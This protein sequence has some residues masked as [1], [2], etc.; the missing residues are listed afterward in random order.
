MSQRDQQLS[1][2]GKSIRETPRSQRQQTTLMKFRTPSRLSSMLPPKNKTPSY[3]PPPSSSTRHN[4]SSTTT[5]MGNT[6]IRTVGAISGTLASL[7]YTPSRAFRSMTNLAV[8]TTRSLAGLTPFK[9]RK[10]RS[11]LLASSSAAASNATIGS[12]LAASTLQTT[13]TTPERRP[14][15]ATE[16]TMECLTTLNVTD[17]QTGEQV[18]GDVRSMV[19]PQQVD[20]TTTLQD[21]MPD[22]E[23][24]Y[25]APNDGEKTTMEGGHGHNGSIGGARKML[26][27]K[28]CKSKS[29]VA[30]DADRSHSNPPSS[31]SMVAE[32]MPVEDEGSASGKNVRSDPRD[33]DVVMELSKLQGSNGEGEAGTT[34]SNSFGQEAREDD[35]SSTNKSNDKGSLSKDIQADYFAEATMPK[36]NH[37][38]GNNLNGRKHYQD[39]EDDDAESNT[40]ASTLDIQGKA[41]EIVLAAS[42]R[43]RDNLKEQQE[44]LNKSRREFQEMNDRAKRDW[45][46][47]YA[48]LEAMQR[49]T[50]AEFSTLRES[51]DTFSKKIASSSH[52]QEL[53]MRTLVS[54]STNEMREESGRAV[55]LISSQAKETK[56]QL[57]S[58]I[59]ALVETEARKYVAEMMEG[60][61]ADA[62][63][64][65]QDWMGVVLNSNKKK[66]VVNA[67]GETVASK[68]TSTGEAASNRIRSHVGDGAI[69]LENESKTRPDLSMNAQ[70]NQSDSLVGCEDADTSSKENRIDAG[71]SVHVP[72]MS[73]RIEPNGVNGDVTDGM[74]S[75]SAPGGFSAGGSISEKENMEPG[76]IISYQ[77]ES[78]T[79][80]VMK[81]IPMGILKA[82]PVKF[83]RSGPVA[84]SPSEGRNHISSTSASSPFSKKSSPL[85][86]G[87]MSSSATPLSRKA[88]PVQNNHAKNKL[89][90]PSCDRSKREIDLECELHNDFSVI[91]S[92][93]F[94]RNANQVNT[95]NEISTDAM[96]KAKAK[97]AKQTSTNEPKHK[98]NVHKKSSSKESKRRNTRN[99]PK[100][101]RM[102]Q[103]KHSCGNTP[104]ERVNNAPRKGG[105]KDKRAPRKKA[106]KT[107]RNTQPKKVH[108]KRGQTTMM[109]VVKSPRRS[110]RL[111]EVH[112]VEHMAAV[113]IATATFAGVIEAK[114]KLRKVTPK[115]DVT[116]PA[117]DEGIDKIAHSSVICHSTSGA[118]VEKAGMGEETGGVSNGYDSLLGT[119]VSVPADDK[120][121][122][123]LIG[124]DEG[125][126]VQPDKRSLTSLLPFGRLRGRK[127]KTMSKTKKMSKKKKSSFDFDF[128][129]F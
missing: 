52:D 106:I 60:L 98:M 72:V 24:S 55:E 123:E 101:N 102:K 13:S 44:A 42:L 114:A 31:T 43:H 104:K 99:P 41:E 48:R 105:V 2:R 96:T 95:T 66:N 124:F 120:R 79:T 20:Q 85:L 117:E 122:D 15:L 65:F 83:N 118:A 54:Q 19:P 128:S 8:K 46:E 62:K 22:I 17:G 127:S 116:P 4:R 56:A 23:M 67:P 71:D 47:E 89:S 28:G 97:A 121:E 109:N 18:T 91:K 10:V 100:S 73:V 108:R 37:K 77:S 76:P 38:A 27:P 87:V 40:S 32:K 29:S 57:P 78:E 7:P 125:D 58:E 21:I 25:F 36:L 34:M 26:T 94:S 69:N 64:E 93:F 112:R 88:T 68:I 126:D 129:F 84:T 111:K 59:R 119:S 45:K 5:N 92:P 81:S 86:C 35:T 53:A 103:D 49:S 30:Q 70:S 11:G 14:E 61:V 9:G 50:E 115:D 3:P 63:S 113:Q 82:D 1:Q 75:I 80:G 74:S 33:N 6:A 110:K 12:T 39:K 107:K 16:K 90:A 51:M